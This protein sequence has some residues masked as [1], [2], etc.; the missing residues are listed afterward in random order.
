ME[1]TIEQITNLT[2]NQPIFLSGKIG[3]Q[4][5]NQWIQQKNEI[6]EAIKDLKEFKD[7]CN[8]LTFG[9][10]NRT[11]NMTWNNQMKKLIRNHK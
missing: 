8:Q 11:H 2:N 4:K 7:I 1:T 9:W 10:E 3:I 5:E 6:V